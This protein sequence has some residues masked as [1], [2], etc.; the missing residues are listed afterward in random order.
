MRRMLVMDLVFLKDISVCLVLEPNLVKLRVTVLVLIIL[1]CLNFW[2][3]PAQATSTASV[4]LT[5]AS[6]LVILRSLSSFLGLALSSHNH[7]SADLPKTTMPTWFFSAS[8]A[9]KEAYEAF[10]SLLR[11][12]PS[13]SVRHWK[14][15]VDPQGGDD[16]SP[17]I[18]PS[19]E[20]RE[21]SL[22]ALSDLLT[23]SSE[24]SGAA[25]SSTSKEFTF[26]TVNGR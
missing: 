10:D 7:T 16:G 12:T 26:L 22:K 11:P 18:Y 19:L 1:R 4:V 23:F 25:E 15:D 24:F 17:H 6:K 5:P 21:D 9:T 13:S 2:L 3:G 14:A 8:F 20:T